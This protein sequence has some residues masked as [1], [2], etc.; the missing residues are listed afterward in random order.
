MPARVL[1]SANLTVRPAEA[2]RACLGLKTSNARCTR[3]R[4]RRGT[5]GSAGGAAEG[6]REA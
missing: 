6:W 1:S 2:D 4:H 3:D 5:T